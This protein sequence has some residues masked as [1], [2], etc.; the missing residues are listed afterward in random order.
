MR[1]AAIER[2]LPAKKRRLRETDVRRGIPSRGEPTMTRRPASSSRGAS[3]AIATIF[4]AHALPAQLAPLP[5]RHEIRSCAVVTG[6]VRGDSLSLHL[7]IPAGCD[8]IALVLAGSAFHPADSG[9]VRW[10]P[11]VRFIPIAVVNNTGHRIRA[12]VQ[13]RADSVLAWGRGARIP[14]SVLLPFID[15]TATQQPWCFAPSRRQCAGDERIDVPALAP[16]AMSSRT[17]MVVELGTLRDSF[18][19]V[20]QIAG[21][22]AAPEVEGARAVAERDVDLTGVA[23]ATSPHAPAPYHRGLIA[24]RFYATPTRGELQRVADV[25]GGALIGARAVAGSWDARDYIFRVPA[26]ATNDGAV[27]LLDQVRRT[28]AD[29]AGLVFAEPFAEPLPALRFPHDTVSVRGEQVE[30]TVIF[31]SVPSDADRALMRTHILGRLGIAMGRITRQGSI[32]GSFDATMHVVI[33]P[34][35][36]ASLA[37]E[38][39][40]EW[41]LTMPNVELVTLASSFPCP[42]HRAKRCYPSLVGVDSL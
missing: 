26:S 33:P 5:P 22:G 25:S 19:M 34:R 7:T 32:P 41:L 18:R 3:A 4:F 30:A 36:G 15:L 27:A 31:H 2:Y 37:G 16:R 42:G 24:A 8:S 40:T 29:G 14:R 12:D 6:A 17:R 10:N 28:Q 9:R 1:I 21:R 38:R 39:L 23:V 11:D 20:L 13:M 35:T